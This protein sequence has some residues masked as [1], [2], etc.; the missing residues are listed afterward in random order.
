MDGYKTQRKKGDGRGE[1]RE[2]EEEI[3]WRAS[4]GEGRDRAKKTGPRQVM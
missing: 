2:R 3:P 4:K 1:E